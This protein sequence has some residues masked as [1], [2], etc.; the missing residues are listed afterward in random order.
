MRSSFIDKRVDNPEGGRYSQSASK[1]GSPSGLPSKTLSSGQDWGFFI[2]SPILPKMR[3]AKKSM[4][5][6]N[7]DVPIMHTYV[8]KSTI[9]LKFCGIVCS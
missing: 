2:V 3:Q 9:F 4:I 7:L 1:R 5:L 6:H 8:T